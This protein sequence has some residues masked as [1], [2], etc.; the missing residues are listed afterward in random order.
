VR[1]AGLS[2]RRGTAGGHTHMHL[3]RLVRNLRQLVTPDKA[4]AL[5]RSRRSILA[6]AGQRASASGS[7][8]VSGFTK[9]PFIWDMTPTVG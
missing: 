4:Y 1:G 6:L 5:G 3:T 2:W 9:K 7:P 8:S